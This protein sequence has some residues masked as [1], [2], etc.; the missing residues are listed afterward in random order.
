M[1]QLTSPSLP[2]WTIL[3]VDR[4]YAPSAG[5]GATGNQVVMIGLNA[6]K[7]SAIANAIIIGNNSGAGGIV[8]LELNGTVIVGQGSLSLL[9]SGTSAIP[10]AQLTAIGNGIAPLITGADSSVMV[11]SNILKLLTGSGFFETSV[12]IG[13]GVCASLTGAGGSPTQDVIIGYHA[14]NSVTAAS[15][16]L[17]CIGAGACSPGTVGTSYQD[18]VFIGLNA[19][20]SATGVASQ[21]VCIGSTSS[22]GGGGTGCVCIGYGSGTSPTEPD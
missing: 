20:N 13:N 5:P 2:G 9:T 15:T 19:G 4:E 14:Q 22:V 21:N 7:N 16:N 12:F 11:G 3:A 18:G 10:D 6:G 8:S 17:V 1:G